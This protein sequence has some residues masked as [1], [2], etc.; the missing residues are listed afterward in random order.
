[1]GFQNV[2]QVMTE[3]RLML[4]GLGVSPVIAAV[5]VIAVVGVVYDRFFN[6]G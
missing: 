2:S 6:K 3:V 5:L 1:M 4:D